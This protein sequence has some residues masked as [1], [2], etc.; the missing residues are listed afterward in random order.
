MT[1]T[2]L[3]RHWQHAAQERQLVV[4]T[5]FEL[6]LDDGSRITVEVLLEGYGA[7]RGMLIVSEFGSL[8]EKQAAIIKAGYGFS[9]MSQPC[10]A[11]VS[12]LDGLDYVLED[13]GTYHSNCTDTLNNAPANRYEK[14]T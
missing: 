3:Q 14:T 4:R 13:W 1:F 7:Q 8:N 2:N 9:C 12:C 6:Q 10:D 5:P 11:E